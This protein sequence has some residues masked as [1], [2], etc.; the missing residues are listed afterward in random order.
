MKLTAVIITL[1]ESRN[2]RRCIKS[3]DG[4]AEEIIVVD[5]Y[6]ADDTVEICKSL[7]AKVI[8]T[9]WKGYSETKNLGNQAAENPYILSIDADEAVSDDLKASISKIK[10]SNEANAYEFNRLTNYCGSWVKHCGWYPD[11]KVRI[12]PKS[13][14]W[15]GDIHESL[16]LDGV[17]I[18]FIKGDLYHYSYYDQKEHR[19]RADKYSALTAR[20]MFDMGKSCGP[21]K[22]FMSGMAKFI[23]IY[24]LKL[25]FLDGRAGWHIAR[26]S[27][28]SNV[29]KYKELRR[30]NN[31]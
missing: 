23:S 4:I 21:L 20:K 7:G 1:N 15:E 22:P 13:V 10:Q 14:E 6:S 17:N 8:Q 29:F 19:A 2:I 31:G 9:E 24:L 27:G 16:N 25:G 5:S 30:L 12:F 28:A 18:Q 11:T 26:I 3:L